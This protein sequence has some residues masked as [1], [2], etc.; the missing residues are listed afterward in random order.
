MQSNQFDG[1]KNYMLDRAS[2]IGT[3]RTFCWKSFQ[4]FVNSQVDHQ[5]EIKENKV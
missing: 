1:N 2:D 4:S 5:V 3:L